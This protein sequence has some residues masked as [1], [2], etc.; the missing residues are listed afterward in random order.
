MKDKD[1]A[2]LRLEEA[3]SRAQ[4]LVKMIQSVLSQDPPQLESL[5]NSLVALL[6][7][8]SSNDGRTDANCNAVDMFF[9]FNNLWVEKNL[10]DPFHDIFADISGALHDTVSS[11]EI[12]E[13]FDSTPEQLLRRAKELST[14]PLRAPDRQETAPAFR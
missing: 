12:A 10:P 8:L 13:N 11:P 6:E 1:I 9:M 14:E 7:Y 3:D 4:D 2:V 5:K